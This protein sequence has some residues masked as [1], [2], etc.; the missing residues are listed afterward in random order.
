[1]ASFCIVERSCRQRVHG[2]T[3]SDAY[4]PGLGEALLLPRIILHDCR[5]VDVSVLAAIYSRQ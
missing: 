1:M 2:P 5:L 4:L 3:L